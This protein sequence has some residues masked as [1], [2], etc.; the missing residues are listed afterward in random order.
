[1]SAFTFTAPIVTKEEEQAEKDELSEEERKQLHDE[2]F[3]LEKA[4]PE[5]D[6]LIQSSLSMF[7]ETIDDLPESDKEVYIEA[8]QQYPRL[9]QKESPALAFLRTNKFDGAAAAHQMAGYW[10][11]R[12]KIFG[13]DR[14]FQPMSVLPNGAMYPEMEFLNTGVILVLPDDRHGRP[15]FF[16]DRIRCTKVVAPRQ[17]ASRCYWYGLQAIAECERAQKLG[18]V[19]IVNLKGCDLYQ[20]FD[21]I[22]SKSTN[23]IMRY[24][25]AACKAVHNCTGSGA[26]VLELIMPVLQQM[27]CRIILISLGIE[28]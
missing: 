6:A 22:L 28:L 20:H 2:I 24:M 1:M 27:V 18:Y 10:K 15:V 19:L 13:Q 8:M 5:S 14:A 3:G 25:P 11:L 7:Y 26:S 23:E 16:W 21:R 4:I 17:N 9:V 12:K